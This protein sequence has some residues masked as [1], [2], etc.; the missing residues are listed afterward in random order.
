MPRQRAF[1]SSACKVPTSRRLQLRSSDDRPSH[2]CRI[3][4]NNRPSQP[5]PPSRPILPH[6]PSSFRRQSSE[7]RVAQDAA[8]ALP[9]RLQPRLT[10]PPASGRALRR[11]TR[12]R[13]GRCSPGSRPWSSRTPAERGTTP[14]RGRGWCRSAPRRPASTRAPT[15]APTASKNNPAPDRRTR[16]SLRWMF[17]K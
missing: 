10:A 5:P 15:P 1:T 16:R 7:E 4:Q 12:H 8:A 14:A 17:L 3:W 11:R 2:S 9:L 6:T 13:G